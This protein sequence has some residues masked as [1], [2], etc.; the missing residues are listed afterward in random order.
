MKFFW[1]C[2]DLWIF[3][4]GHHKTGL[5]LRVISVHFRVFS[6]GKCT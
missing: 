2:E 5:V 4:G 6:C 3:Y 1:G